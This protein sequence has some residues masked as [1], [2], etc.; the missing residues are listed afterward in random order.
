MTCCTPCTKKKATKHRTFPEKILTHNLYGIEI[1]ER[2]GELA[3]FALT[4]KARAK[5]RRFFNKGIKPNICVLQNIHFDADELDSYMTFIGQDLF[6]APLRTTLTQF[7]EVDNFGSLIR[8]ALTD[9]EDIK[10]TLN[11]KNVSG[12]LFLSNTH[13]KVLTA[14]QQT[15]YLSPKYHVVI[16]NP[17]Y[18]GG[19]GM[20][21]RL[22]TWAKDQYP[23][24]KSDLFAMFIERGFDL[25]PKYGYSAMVTMQS[26]MFLSSY[27]ALRKRILDETSIECL[28]HM[29]NMVMGIA[30]GTAATVLKKGGSPESRG[31]Y[32]YVEY[33]DIGE[34][35][36]PVE[37]PP[38][39]ERNSKAT[40]RPVNV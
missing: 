36:T 19:K 10:R 31:A 21:G 7:E 26:W 9:V 20:N 3:A 39:N 23:A 30:F 22:S 35:G 18:M 25:T 6:T 40:Q 17:P 29:A 24:S 12:E 28:V 13:Q 37:F 32:C 5:Q 27:E 34:D 2:A 16:A 38:K 15:D 1:D 8:P 4:M 14:L 33:E 11:A